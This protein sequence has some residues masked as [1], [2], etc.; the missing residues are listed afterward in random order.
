MIHHKNSPS[1]EFTKPKQI[2]LSKI[3]SFSYV[4]F[5]LPKVY[6]KKIEQPKKN[7]QTNLHSPPPGDVLLS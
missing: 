1:E 4:S 3:H 7:K 2:H 6:T 5:S